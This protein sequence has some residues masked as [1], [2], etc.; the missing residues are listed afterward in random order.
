MKSCVVRIVSNTYRFRLHVLCRPYRRR[1]V[2]ALKL[3]TL[4]LL[5]IQPTVF[6]DQEMKSNR[7][8][9]HVTLFMIFVYTLRVEAVPSTHQPLEFVQ[10]AC[11][12]LCGK[13]QVFTAVLLRP[14]L[15]LEPM[16]PRPARRRAHT[17]R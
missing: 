6:C 12:K 11:M 1:R 2:V 5:W 14:A 16:I 3:S 9:C 13:Y 4:I 15:V 7:M 8:A 17:L 10:S